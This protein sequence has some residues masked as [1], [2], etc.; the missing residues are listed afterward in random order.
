MLI[1]SP[2]TLS[3]RTFAAEVRRSPRGTLLVAEADQHH[4]L[5]N[6]ICCCSRLVGVKANHV[7]LHL[8]CALICASKC[9]LGLQEQRDNVGGSGRTARKERQGGTAPAFKHP[10][11]LLP[12]F[13]AFRS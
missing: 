10:G 6:S 2:L 11:E 1:N 3:H 5:C 12:P 7:F 9:D 13:R 8:Q 4:N